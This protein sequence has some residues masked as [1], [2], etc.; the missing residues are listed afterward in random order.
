MGV[1]MGGTEYEE[2]FRASFFV[3]S[4]RLSFG[5]RTGPDCP[6]F[7]SHTFAQGSHQLRLEAAGRKVTRH[8]SG[9]CIAIF[10]LATK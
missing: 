1:R 7:C 10:S 2:A 8:D 9:D 4:Q 5:V 3:P 6:I